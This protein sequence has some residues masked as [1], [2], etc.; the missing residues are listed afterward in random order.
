MILIYITCKDKEQA[1]FIGRTLLD[2]KLCACINIIPGMQ[3]LYFWPP[4]TGELETA[5]ETILIIKSLESKYKEIED[6]VREIHSYKNPCIFSW[7]IDQVSPQYYEWI[8]GE[9]S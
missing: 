1:E 7:K 2:K 3:S 5:N 9:L 6:K 8:K 4:K